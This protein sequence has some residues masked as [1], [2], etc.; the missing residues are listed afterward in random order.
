MEVNDS[1]INVFFI[2]QIIN[3]CIFDVVL[4]NIFQSTHVFAKIDGL[5]TLQSCINQAQRRQP[6]KKMFHNV[7]HTNLN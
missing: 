3:I 6:L 1:F 4:K 7:V 5:G 2:F